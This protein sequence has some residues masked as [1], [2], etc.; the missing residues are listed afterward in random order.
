MLDGLVTT[1]HLA[2]MIE[3]KIAE[4]GHQI[5]IIQADI[6]LLPGFCLWIAQ[7]GKVL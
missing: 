1:G 7:P 6:V 3:S 4:G 2:D 5:P